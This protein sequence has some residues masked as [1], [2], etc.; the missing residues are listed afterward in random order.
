MSNLESS[1]ENF[2]RR[3]AAAAQEARHQAGRQAA[4]SAAASRGTAPAG[5]ARAEKAWAQEARQMARR[6][7][8]SRERLLGRHSGGHSEVG[9]K[10]SLRSSP[11]A[12]LA[13]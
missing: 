4:I 13:K 1:W 3:T 12:G 11:F 7:E 2:G 5:D 8:Q 9:Q 6:E 10:A